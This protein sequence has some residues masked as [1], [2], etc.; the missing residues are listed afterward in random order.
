MQKEIDLRSLSQAF[1]SERVKEWIEEFSSIGKDPEGGI[2]RPG[3]SKEE[4]MA[5]EKAISIMKDL[6]LEI[7]VDQF[8]NVI[9]RRAGN[10][11]HSPPI[12][13]GSHLDTV[14]N[15]GG[16][17][18]TAGV[19]AALEAIRVLNV[20]EILTLHPIE[21]IVFTSEEPNRFGI[22]AF[23]S[24][25][26]SGKLDFGQLSQ[27][28]DETG[29]LLSSA[30]ISIGINWDSLQKDY[31]PPD[32]RAFIELHVEQGERLY[33]R[34]IPIGVVL[35]VAGI[36]RHR[37]S[38]Y[39]KANHSGT[40][41]MSSRKD[42]LMATA[43]AILAAEQSALS[44]GDENATAT[45]GSIQVKP[46]QVNI[47]PGE[48]TFSIEFRSFFPEVLN[49]MEKRLKESLEKIQKRRGLEI[50]S[51]TALFQ[52]PIKFSEKVIKLIR[53]SAADLHLPSL[54]LV[55]MAGHDANHMASITHAGMIFIPSRGGMSHC[56]EEW[57][58]PR[59]IVAGSMVLCNTIL[60]IDGEN[61]WKQD[62]NVSH[63]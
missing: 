51:Q 55:S 28:K 35:G 13:T 33:K 31:K 12:M 22:S 29:I 54:E 53:Q 37:V 19:V 45:V 23:G 11:P 32:L 17:D 30:L 48:V 27:L 50:F 18:G 3:L 46:N 15:G 21:V 47:I 36:D 10:N 49:K 60:K 7:R 25:G 4:K 52:P 63:P 26:F 42:A 59:D 1:K 8:G 20:C 61:L 41:P 14:R 62:Q 9:G 5:K 40:T 56:K 39:G 16:F 38:I 6:G 24:K 44:E 57:S 2:T 43:E 58:D 34:K